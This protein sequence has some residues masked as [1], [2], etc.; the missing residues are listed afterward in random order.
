MRDGNHYKMFTNPILKPLIDIIAVM[1]AVRS[2]V[3]IFRHI[4]LEHVFMCTDAHATKE[5]QGATSVH[6]TSR[7]PW[8]TQLFLST[9]GID[10]IAPV[11]KTV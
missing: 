5:R 4:S 1:S 7:T 8:K 3:E 9:A 6:S 10:S 2:K 11:M